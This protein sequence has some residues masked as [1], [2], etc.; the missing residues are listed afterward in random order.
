MN[1]PTPPRSTQAT[2]RQGLSFVRARRKRQVDDLIED[3]ITWREACAAV[4]VAYE[5]WTQAAPQEREIEFLVYTVALDREEHA[6]L[7]YQL[8]VAGVTTAQIPR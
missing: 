5:R 2:P 3:Y 7:T 1:Q 4:D 8:S 6:A